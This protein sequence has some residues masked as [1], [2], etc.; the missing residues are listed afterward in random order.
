MK[1][2]VLAIALGSLFISANASA[3]D[4][5]WNWFAG[6]DDDY[7]MEPTASL[8]VGSMK[9]KDG[10]SG[11]ISGIELSF[12]C[13]LVQPPTN[14]IRQQISYAK[15]DE[16]GT[17]VTTIEINPHYVV[18]TSPGLSIGA[19]PGLGYVSVDTPAKDESMLAIQLGAS[20]HYN[21]SDV[22]FVGG[23]ARYQITQDENLGGSVEGLDNWRV[24]LKAGM[25]F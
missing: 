4:G 18:E 2:K 23:E 11:S 13:P 10:S 20:V 9:P 25:N 15:Y 14:K 16:A 6:A 21:A 22:F 3:A 19:G 17:E 1:K 8:L 5:E 7:V 12:N 24:A